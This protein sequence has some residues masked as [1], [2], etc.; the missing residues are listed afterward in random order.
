MVIQ[1]FGG[2]TIMPR[3]REIKGKVLVCRGNQL[4]F[5]PADGAPD[6]AA[7]MQAEVGIPAGGTAV[8]LR[9]LAV[10]RIKEISSGCLDLLAGLSLQEDLTGIGRMED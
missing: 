7:V 3:G 1:F 8:G 6:L 10:I 2:K 4:T 9:H 5:A